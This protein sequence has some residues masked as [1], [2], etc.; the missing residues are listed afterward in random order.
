MMLKHSKK[1]K[2]FANLRHREVLSQFRPT[3]QHCKAKMAGHLQ[4]NRNLAEQQCFLIQYATKIPFVSLGTL[5]VPKT[6]I[7]SQYQDWEISTAKNPGKPAPENSFPGHSLVG[8]FHPYWLGC[9]GL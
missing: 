2:G 4:K 3:F 6:K 8:S 5:A 1:E 9:R 7:P